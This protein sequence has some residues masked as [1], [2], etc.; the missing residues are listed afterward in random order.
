[1]KRLDFRVPNVV[2]ELEEARE[3]VREACSAPRVCV[4]GRHV[5][6][7]YALRLLDGVLLLR[8]C[9]LLSCT[10]PLSRKQTSGH[11]PEWV[12]VKDRSPVHTVAAIMMEEVVRTGLRVAMARGAQR[13]GDAL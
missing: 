9:C 8:S 13:H 12:A 10:C 5:E 6:T 2:V 3:Y 7:A 4:C 1:V 11:I